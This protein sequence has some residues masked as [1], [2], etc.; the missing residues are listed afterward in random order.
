METIIYHSLGLG[1]NFDELLRVA[2]DLKTADAFFLATPAGWRPG[3]DVIVPAA[4]SCGVARE[5]ME[6]KV[7]DVT[8]HDWFFCTKKIDKEKVLAAIK[9]KA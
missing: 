9:S 3:D 5:R 4:G 2:Q 1:R 8:C 6:G 7:E